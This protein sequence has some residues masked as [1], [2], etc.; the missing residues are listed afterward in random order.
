MYKCGQPLPEQCFFDTHCTAVRRK[1]GDGL[2][3]NGKA[4]FGRCGELQRIAEQLFP[5]TVQS[6]EGRRRWFNPI[7]C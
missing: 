6:Y 3:R 1:P 2:P 7:N 4:A 5:I